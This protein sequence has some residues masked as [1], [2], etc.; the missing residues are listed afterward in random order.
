MLVCTKAESPVARWE[1]L[2]K[3][4]GYEVVELDTR[5]VTVRGDSGDQTEVRLVCISDT[6]TRH[7]GV[8]VPDGGW[9]V[10][11]CFTDT[12]T[13]GDILVHA[14]DFTRYGMVAEVVAFNQWR[15][16]LPH[17]VRWCSEE[18]FPIVRCPLS[19]TRS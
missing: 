14:G 6:H 8:E 10:M 3:E 12:R 2:S 5:E 13:S 9:T 4:A 11:K 17:K 1:E 7:E 16:R 15:A 19:S 18:L